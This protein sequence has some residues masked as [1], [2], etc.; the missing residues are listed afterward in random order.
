MLTPTDYVTCTTLLSLQV[1]LLK[2]EL[3]SFVTAML[4]FIRF[5]ARTLNRNPLIPSSNMW[6]NY[7]TAVEDMV[8]PK[9]RVTNKTIRSYFSY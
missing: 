7:R 9:L 1:K 8:V 5:V 3:G 4:R 2:K 6:H